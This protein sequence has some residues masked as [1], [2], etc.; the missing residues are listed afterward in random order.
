MVSKMREDIESM[1]THCENNVNGE[2]C[3]GIA[4]EHCELNRKYRGMVGI[5]IEESI[6]Y[7]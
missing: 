4:C 5:G 6:D 2:K 1:E 3:A 7:N